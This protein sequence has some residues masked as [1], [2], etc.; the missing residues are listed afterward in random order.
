MVAPSEDALSLPVSASFNLLSAISTSIPKPWP[1]ADKVA[2][3][4]AMGLARGHPDRI[5]IS[6]TQDK[7][8]TRRWP[9]S[10]TFAERMSFRLEPLSPPRQFSPVVDHLRQQ[11]N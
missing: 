9:M 8:S 4:F 5:A 10:A 2:W 1:F 7:W 11:H 6:W 3:R